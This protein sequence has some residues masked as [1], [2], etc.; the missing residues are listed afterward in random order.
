MTR[1]VLLLFLALLLIP[2]RTLGGQ[3]LR[4]VPKKVDPHGTY[5]IY[6]HGRIIEEEGVRPTSQRFGVYEYEKILADLA[7]RG[8]TVISEPR[9]RGTDVGRYA[10]KVVAQVRTLL[11]RGVPPERITVVG[12]SKGGAIALVTSSRLR[13]PKV[14]FAILAGCGAWVSDHF[15]L[16]LQ[17]RVLSMRDATDDL[18][19]SCEKIFA[20]SKGGLAHEEIVLQLGLGHGVFFRPGDWMGAVAAWIRQA[21]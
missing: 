11:A 10:D 16:N 19:T 18:S 5:L 6:L 13:Q 14:N 2:A 9:P 8:F 4:D 20:A 17:G 12:F 7:A 15:D 1:L 3:A 21:G